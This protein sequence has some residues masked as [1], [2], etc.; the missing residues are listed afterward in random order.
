MPPSLHLRTPCRLG[1]G[2]LMH[3]CWRRVSMQESIAVTLSCMRA[4]SA[5]VMIGGGAT[6]SPQPALGAVM[7]N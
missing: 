6:I 5:P 7:A 2:D 3:A 1:C 4:P